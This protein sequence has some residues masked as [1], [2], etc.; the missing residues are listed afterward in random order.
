MGPPH[1]QLGANVTA[2]YVFHWPYMAPEYTTAWLRARI[3]GELGQGLGVS[4]REGE[5]VG[6]AWFLLRA[7]CLVVYGIS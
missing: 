3:P 4:D 5:R 7:S 1:L 2:I 6:S